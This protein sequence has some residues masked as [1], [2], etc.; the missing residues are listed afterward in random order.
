ME[1]KK[2]FVA[3]MSELLNM[4]KPHL[5]CE[6]LKDCNGEYVIVHCANRHQYKIDVTAD[7]ECCIAAEVFKA[8][9]GK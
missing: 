4:A 1:N 3:K 9:C 5:A 6:Y 7:N 8:M 2:E